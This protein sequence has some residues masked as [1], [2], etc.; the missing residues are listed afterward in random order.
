MKIKDLAAV[1][2]VAIGVPHMAAAQDFNVYGGVTATTN[3]VFRGVTFSDD[4]PALQP[5]LEAEYKGFYAGIWASNVDFGPDGTDDYEVDY[6]IGYR[7]ETSGGFSYD[8]NYARFT[9]D[10]TGDCCGEFNVVLGL[11]VGEKTE[12]SAVFAYDP[13]ANALA[14]ALG[15][16]Y[17]INDLWSVSASFGH[18]ELLAHNYWDAGVG[19]T[20]ND[21]TSLDLRYHDTSDGDSLF[22]ASVSFDFTLLSR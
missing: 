21:T 13:D 14:S 15:A 10:D 6:Y 2:A 7:G 19:Y 8:V 4:G 9:F 11:P 20:I 1:A 12:V 3:Y 5:Y 22:V 18:D 16:S 17:A